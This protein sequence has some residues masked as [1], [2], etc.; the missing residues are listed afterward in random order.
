MC[1]TNQNTVVVCV[2]NPSFCGRLIETGKKLAQVTGAQ[3]QIIHICPQSG[4]KDTKALES[5]YQISKDAQAELTV[6]FSD[7]PVLT[8]ALC[9]EETH[10]T[11]VV[12]GMPDMNRTGFV[13]LLRQMVPQV[14]IT[15]VGVDG[16]TYHIFPQFS[17]IS[18]HS[19]SGEG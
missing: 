11:Q 1:Q 14:T 18:R 10:A 19:S 6:F 12:T 13:D 7:N 2:Q 16:L 5:L 4:E 8:A 3:L 17:S 15:M 9:I